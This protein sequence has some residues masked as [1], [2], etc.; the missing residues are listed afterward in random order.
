MSKPKDIDYRQILKSLTRDEKRSLTALTNHH[1]ATH[2]FGHLG[3]IAIM[4][5]LNATQTGTL[6]ALAMLGQ[7]IGM[8]FLFCA[9]H[10]ASHGTAFKTSLFNKGLSLFVGLLIFQGPL[11]FKSFHAAHH[12]HTHDPDHDPEL[13]S[14]KPQHWRAYL[15]HL[16]GIMI[17]ISSIKTLISN[18]ITTPQD[19]FIPSSARKSVQQEA[20]LMVLF[21]LSLFTLG[22]YIVPTT[23]AD[24]IIWFWLIPLLLGQPFL[25]LFLLAEHA[26]CAQDPDML[27]NSRTT[28]TNPLVLFLSWNMPYHTAHHSFP[29]VP[30]HQ[31]KTFNSFI[32]RH[33]A[34]IENGY[35][36]FH[37]GYMKELKA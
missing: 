31:L 8:C 25:R 3:L 13:A 23:F 1:A 14:P 28:R 30:F 19:S 2:L 22:A 29:A 27:K 18:A 15:A 32:E 37:H 5:W 17:W 21:Y 34:S 11:W 24:I 6:A 33:T 16:S 35:T 9:M 7:G 12:R 26:G 20:R 4:I 36:R 10:E